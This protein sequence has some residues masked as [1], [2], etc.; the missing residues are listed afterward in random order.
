M[1]VYRFFAR[2]IES[3]FP[4]PEL[5]PA[6]GCRAD[7]QI[8][9]ASPPCQFGIFL[10]NLELPDGTRWARL[11]RRDSSF[12]LEFPDTTIFEIGAD[13]QT[14][15]CSPCSSLPRGTLRH[16]LLN[17]VLPFAFAQG[18]AVVLH[19]SGVVVD[20]RTV[21]FLGPAG[22]GKSTLA[23]SLGSHF[24][25]ISDDALLLT[26]NGGEIEAVGSYADLRL[27]A[28][29]VAQL[30]PRAATK[31]VLAHFSD[32]RHTNGDGVFR[33]EVH[34]KRLTRL[35][36]LSPGDQLGI[37]S[38]PPADAVVELLRHAYRLD[39]DDYGR[40]AADQLVFARIVK[41]GLVRWLRLRHNFSE[42]EQIKHLMMEDL[43]SGQ[44][45]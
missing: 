1:A 23:A 22:F 24:P 5:R 3:S 39:V 41:N 12:Q 13:G 10:R 2:A 19:A 45:T 28:D 44:G 42:L 16:L 43:G 26:E 8:R 25:V 6:A 35:Y 37:E 9:I 7:I 15:V 36:R 4:I 32:K 40:L 17:Q 27:W 21:A 33:F 18:G 34:P 31:K 20:Q 30:I 14:I 11:R 29:S 38:I